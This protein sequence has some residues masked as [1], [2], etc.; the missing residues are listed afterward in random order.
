[1]TVGQRVI[2]NVGRVRGQAGVIM[3]AWRERGCGCQS[4]AVKLDSG[5][6]WAGKTSEVRAA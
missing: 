3:G 1:M 4:V 2:I 5:R 6:E